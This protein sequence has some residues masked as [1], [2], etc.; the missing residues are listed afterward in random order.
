MLKKSCVKL[1]FLLFRAAPAAHGGSQAM[2]RIGA[3]AAGL[4]HSPSNEGSLNP[5]S[6][7]GD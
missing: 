7:A 4:C 6:E 1:F 3:T 5:L 2:G